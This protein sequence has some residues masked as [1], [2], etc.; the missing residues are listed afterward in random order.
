MEGAEFRWERETDGVQRILLRLNITDTA[1]EGPL[2]LTVAPLKLH[3]KIDTLTGK[4]LM[5]VLEKDISIT[6]EKIKA[7]IPPEKV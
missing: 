7:P 3:W 2:S 5:S 4:S 6:L 1:K